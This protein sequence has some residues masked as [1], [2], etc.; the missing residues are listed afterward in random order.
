MLL[1]AVTASAAERPVTA[2]DARELFTRIKS[3][4]GTWTAKSTKGW[5]EKNTYEV[6]G[7]GSVV[8]NRSFFEGEANDGM[9]TTWFLDGDR[10]L[11][12][13]YCEAGNQ[14]TLVAKTIDPENNRVT[15]EFLSGT[16]LSVRPGH[17]HATVMQFVDA[18]H[19]RSRWSFY[20]DGK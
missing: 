16:N 4:A 20:R 11:L 12:T 7:K 9:V 8:I 18:D 1:V 10:L 3:L 15:F 2:A 19:V 5:T 14:P 6:A 13:H 17:M